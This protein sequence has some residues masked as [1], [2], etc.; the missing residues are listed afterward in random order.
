[1]KDRPALFLLAAA[2]MMFLAS[3]GSPIAHRIEKNPGMFAKLSDS[4]KALV[5]RG[6]IAEGMSKDAVFIAWGRPDRVSSGTHAGKPLER[7]SYKAYEAVHG[8]AFGVGIGGGYWG[9]RPFL[10]GYYGY[11]TFYAEPTVNYVPYEARRVDFTNGRV[12]GWVAAH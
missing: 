4:E 5:Q 2:A 9:H 10:G 1:M 6:E 8:T 7:W 3:C 12:I 11:D